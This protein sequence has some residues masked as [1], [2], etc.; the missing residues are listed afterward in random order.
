MSIVFLADLA[1]VVDVPPVRLLKPLAVIGR[2]LHEYFDREPWI[3][4]TDW[5]KHSCILCAL[6]VR[7]YLRRLGFAAR[8]RPVCV[9]MGATQDGRQLHSLGIGQPGDP[10]R[11][12][13]WP[14]HL[15]TE[16]EGILI[17]T[18][19]YPA[20]REHWPRLPGMTAVP[21]K[22]ITDPEAQRFGLWP[23]AGLN[24]TNDDPGYD[25]SL[26]WFDNPD[27]RSWLAAP[28]AKAARRANVVNQLAAATKPWPL[29]GE[30]A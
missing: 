29:T 27:N 25:F 26:G 2:Y 1:L 4:S 6:T 20:R 3:V 8:V 12:N 15:V 22:R 14:G 17:D 9:I 19:L 18:T 13:G 23:I 24:M 28:D 5:S 16:C 7:D 21:I 10:P 11:Q 30:G